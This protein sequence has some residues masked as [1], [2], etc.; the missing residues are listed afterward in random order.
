MTEFM[1]IEQVHNVVIGL[2]P[3]YSDIGDVTEIITA[4]G[5][6]YQ[7]SRKLRTVRKTLARSYG[8][9]LAGQAE[10]IA[11]EINKQAIMPFFIESQRVFIPLKMRTPVS[12]NDSA[13]GYI[14][15]RYIIKVEPVE[16]ENQC[17]V[18]L[19]NELKIPVLNSQ[20][21]VLNNQHVGQV[22][23]L[24]NHQELDSESKEEQLL[25]E[26]ARILIKTVKGIRIHLN[27]TED[28][29]P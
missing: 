14:D 8:I 3:I 21:V 17:L 9:D 29:D 22:L 1:K 15:V 20:A 11:A 19:S 28:T 13:Y 10:M 2:R 25:M 24:R 12:A 26:S 27:K 7:D 4:S 16:E 6:I 18:H 23:L 5:D